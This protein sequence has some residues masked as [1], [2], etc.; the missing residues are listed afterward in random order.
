MLV[1]A[2]VAGAGLN[3]AMYPTKGIGIL[4]AAKTDF[5]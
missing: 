4:G 3:V 1:V 5:G 2:E